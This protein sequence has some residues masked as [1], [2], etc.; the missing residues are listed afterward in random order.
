VLDA[1]IVWTGNAVGED[2]ADRLAYLTNG[3]H[4]AWY[5]S[6]RFTLI[7][8]FVGAAIAVLFGLLGAAALRS[9]FAP[10]RWLGTVYTTMVRG[11]PDV[12][13]FLFF[14]LAFEQAVEWFMA[15]R[16]CGAEVLANATSWPPC[17]AAQ[18]YLGTG[19]YLALACVSLGIVYGAFA[20]N[21]IN[22]AMTAV[23]RGQLE[24]ASAYGFTQRQIF[25]RFQVRQMWIYALPGL[26][27]VWMLLLKA[28]SLLSLL[29]IQDMVLWANRIG[30]PNYIARVGTVHGDWRWRYY[31]AL[32]VF[33]ILLTLISEYIFRRMSERAS[34]GMAIG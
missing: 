21:V 9:G 20:A 34:R 2:W 22:G 24:A 7:A 30:A 26:S 6:V 10:L 14:P 31:L 17:Q 15:Q 4:L 25:W 23:P 19:E 8:A 27:N 12:L 3:E 1:L 13:F 29:Q 33:Y 16:A 5:A 28:T 18:W 32:F 11:I